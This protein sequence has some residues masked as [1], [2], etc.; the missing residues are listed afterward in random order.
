VVISCKDSG[1]CFI[2]GLTHDLNQQSTPAAL[3]IL[4]LVSKR[5]G[6]TDFSR[7]RLNDKS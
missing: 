7:R 5:L 2:V 1:G 6:G 3:I 4:G